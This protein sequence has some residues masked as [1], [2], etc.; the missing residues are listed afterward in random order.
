[1]RFMIENIRF[2]PSIRK[3]EAGV[4]NNLHSEGRFRKPA[5]LVLEK[6]LYVWTGE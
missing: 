5:F 2:R 3:R 4:F 1:M 6:D